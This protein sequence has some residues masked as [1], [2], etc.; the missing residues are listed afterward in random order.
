MTFDKRLFEELLKEASESPR[1]RG[2]RDLRN[3][4]ADLSQRMLNALLPGTEVP[5]HRH[6][7]TSETVAVLWGRLTEVFFD[8]KGEVTDEFALDADGDVRGLSIPRGQWHTVRVTEPCVIVEMKEGP[9][10]PRKEE[11]IKG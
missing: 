11:D 9:Y 2:A 4:E 5:I 7:E 6:E 1:L 8:E 10:R 3:S